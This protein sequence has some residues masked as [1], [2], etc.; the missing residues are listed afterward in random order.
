M[1]PERRDSA[2]HRHDERRWYEND[3]RL[4]EIRHAVEAF[5]GF[6]DYERVGRLGPKRPLDPERGMRDHLL[7]FLVGDTAAGAVRPTDDSRL[8]GHVMIISSSL[9]IESLVFLQ[10]P[11]LGRAQRRNSFI[12]PV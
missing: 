11:R 2:G 8:F 6:L 4:V 1:P 12:P 10:K 7:P 3:T 5:D 9:V